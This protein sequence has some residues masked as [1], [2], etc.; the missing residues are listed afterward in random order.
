MNRAEKIDSRRG[1]RVKLVHHLHLVRNLKAPK[2]RA[3]VRH[4]VRASLKGSDPSLRLG[5]F[6]L[7]HQWAAFQ[8]WCLGDQP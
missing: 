1:V 5:E 4:K 3:R 8:G 2:F 6:S 7:H